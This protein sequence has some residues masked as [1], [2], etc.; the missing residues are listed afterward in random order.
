MENENH[1]LTWWKTAIGYIIYPSS[2][3]DSNDDG[4]G[5][6]PG[7]ISKL[8]YLRD[9]GINLLWICPF[10]KSPM[11]DNGYDVSDYRKID[12]RFGTNEDFDNLIKEAHKRNIRIVIDFVLNHTSDEHP[13]F[14]EA[15]DNPKSEKR[16]YYLFA[17][18][19]FE[20]G[21]RLPPNNWKGFFSTST[22]TYDDKSQLYYMHIFSKKMPD[23]N[24]AN[25]SL[26]EE[27]HQIAKYYLDK[28]VD[29]FRL[30]ALAHLA[31]DLSFAD[32]RLPKDES[33]LC[34]DTAKYSNR[35]ELFDYMREF[36]EKV[37]SKYDCVTIGEVG[38]GISPEESLQLSGYKN[39][40][41]N[42]V[43]NFDTAW[44]NGAYDSLDKKDEQIV[45]NVRNLKRNFARWHAIC[46]GKA[47]MPLYWDNHDH[48]RV[49]SQYGSVAYR[50][51]SAKML[52]T[53]LLFMYGTPFIYYGDEIGM[54]NVDY[55]NIND[56][57]DV[58]ARNYLIENQGKADLPTLLRFLRRTSRVNA[59]TP[60]QWSDEKF[61]GF[62]RVSPLQKINGNYRQINVKNQESDPL[63]ILS[64]YK[65][66]IALRKKQDI[67][68]TV[69]FGD[70][71]FLD[72]DNEDI[73]AY[74]HLGVKKIALIANFRSKTVFFNLDKPIRSTLLHNYSD[75]IIVNGDIT[76][77]P[78]EC[79]L[80][81]LV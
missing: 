59:R 75:E 77:R 54:S 27:Y 78:F 11:D 70:F 22:W 68:D 18:P 8:D 43:F 67:S 53:T 26:R 36:K 60:M 20:N 40:S 37:F 71:T 69:L 74:T 19:K 52:I 62:S 56:F 34:Y 51:E 45:T 17:Q 5:D 13:W 50:N 44:E 76:L 28:G 49:L 7:I 55:D 38:G 32:S 42:M 47:W 9:L 63:S 39:G 14:I 23:V 58:S 1:K 41:I 48:P 10:F 21:K 35:P 30:D 29:G 4:I 33:G 6:L 80:L 16:A 64:Y 46:N 66:A 31:R 15:R 79:F 81:E 2:F 73:F 25:P 72:F 3:K 61:A 57:N 65:T 24:W 12:P